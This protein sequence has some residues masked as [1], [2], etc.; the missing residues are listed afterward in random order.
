MKIDPVRVWQKYQKLHPTPAANVD[1]DVVFCQPTSKPDK[2]PS[3]PEQDARLVA[4][5]A[6]MAKAEKRRIEAHARLIEVVGPAL[7]AYRDLLLRMP[8]YSPEMCRATKVAV[9]GSVR[10][11][12]R[13]ILR[14]ETA[15]LRLLVEEAKARLR[16]NGARPRGGISAAALDKVAKQLGLPS[17]AALKKRLQRYK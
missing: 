4:A 10:Q 16:K 14:Q 13:Q 7:P 11:Y 8:W 5:N 15:N 6:V 12:D 1:V 17:G 3:T 9:S 2:K